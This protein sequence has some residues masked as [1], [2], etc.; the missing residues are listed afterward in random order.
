MLKW[1][2]GTQPETPTDFACKAMQDFFDKQK[3]EIK[4]GVKDREDPNVKI[5][6]QPGGWDSFGASIGDM[7]EADDMAVRTQR[8]GFI[9]GQMSKDPLKPKSVEV[10]F[11]SISAPDGHMLQ[12]YV[13][14]WVAQQ[15]VV[16][17]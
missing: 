10:D 11:N 1:F 3:I 14:K 6:I 12:H 17:R 16:Q 5:V 2:R 8:V 4:V 13:E 7:G 9:L 15:Q